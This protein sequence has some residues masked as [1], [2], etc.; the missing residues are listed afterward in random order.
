M[1]AIEF[2]DTYKDIWQDVIRIVPQWVHD[3][4]MENI[5]RAKIKALEGA[6]RQYDRARHWMNNI[7]SNRE[8]G[9]A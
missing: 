7:Y 3:W 9:V 2:Y 1:G 8:D 4:M 6:R 5:N